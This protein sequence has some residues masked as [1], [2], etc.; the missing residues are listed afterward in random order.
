M[1]EEVSASSAYSA[2]TPGLRSY[3][4]FVTASLSG[5]FAEL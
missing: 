2:S 5:D 3:I 4:S 1:A